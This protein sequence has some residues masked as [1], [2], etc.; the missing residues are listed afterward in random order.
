MRF[1]RALVGWLLAGLILLAILYIP[2]RL[3]MLAW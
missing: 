2:L 3:A 1:I